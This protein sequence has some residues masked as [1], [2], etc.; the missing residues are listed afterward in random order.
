M[1]LLIN[2][3]IYAMELV[4]Q[5][6]CTCGINNANNNDETKN[7]LMITIIVVSFIAAILLLIVNHCFDAREKDKK[8]KEIDQIAKPSIRRLVNFYTRIE[9]SLKIIKEENKRFNKEL[10]I[11]KYNDCLDLLGET[12]DN[13]LD[14]SSQDVHE[15]VRG[16]HARRSVESLVNN[17]IEEQQEIAN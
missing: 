12:K 17:S 13:W 6:Y 1:K 8:Q 2:I 3:L 4:V 11:Q 7:K 9:A 14:I 10:T 5:I 16:Y 15:Y